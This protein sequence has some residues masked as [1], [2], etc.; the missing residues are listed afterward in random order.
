MRLWTWR[1]TRLLAGASLLIPILFAAACSGGDPQ[2]T[3]APGGDVAKMTADLFWP[4]FWIA[5]GVF[6]LV[7]GLLVVSMFVFRE[8]RGRGR[9]VQ[10]HGS[11]RLEITWTAIP[12]VLL[13]GIAIPT[14]TTLIR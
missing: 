8:R 2:N 12:A 5:V 9:P 3:L 11:T 7:E 4:V 10:V 1:P 14:I 6:V 13:L